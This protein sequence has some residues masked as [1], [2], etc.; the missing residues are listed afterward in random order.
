M[1]RI[2][3]YPPRCLLILLSFAGLLHFDSSPLPLLWAQEI[4]DSQKET[5]PKMTPAE[6]VRTAK[7]PEG[8]KITAVA[9]EPNVQQPIAMAWDPLGRLLI[10]ENYTYAES[11]LRVDHALSD[12]IVILEDADHDGVFEN[13]KVFAEGLQGLTS[14]EF[15]GP[16]KR[17]VWALAPP[18]LLFIPDYD[19]DGVADTKPQVV[20]RGFNAQIRHNFANGLRFGPDGW[21]Y[22]RH[23]ILGASEVSIPTAITI[24]RPPG[25]VAPT[26]KL[27]C[28]IWRFHP[29]EERI[30]M[31]CEGTTNPW[32][33]DWDEHG[34]LFFINT[35]IGHLWH[36]IPN[37]HLERMYGEDSDPY[38]YELIPQVADHVHW[39]SSAEDW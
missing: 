9:S 24:P 32:G 8:F 23:G 16:N 38:A 27:T 15:G 22:G 19:G 29:I 39:D 3:T 26:H 30:E 4:Y 37:S 34:N 2:S 12:R 11:A 25:Y 13:R 17:G 31:V 33:M 5:I 10:A 7:L 35:V 1:C 21:L 28:G 6:A 18:H 20:V 36:A 14:I